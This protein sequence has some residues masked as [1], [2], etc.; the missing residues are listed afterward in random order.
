MRCFIKLLVVVV[1]L[2]ASLVAAEETIVLQP[3]EEGKDAYVSENYSEN[4]FGGSMNL[5]LATASGHLVMA[6]YI[7][8]DLSA[9]PAGAQIS[10]AELEFFCVILDPDDK[11]SGM[12]IILDLVTEGWDEM[13]ITWDNQP[14]S[15]DA[16]R[17]VY[18]AWPLDDDWWP[19]VEVTEFV[20]AWCGGS[21]PNHGFYIYL[22]PPSTD[23]VRIGSYSSDWAGGL[24]LEPKLTI[25][26]SGS[27]IEPASWGAIK[28]AD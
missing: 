9:V 25:T 14:A 22:D 15:S 13:T 6:T 16:V 27:K 3:G 5:E 26:Y 12:N 21:H 17:V 2:S 4:N 10:S 18:P 24:E 8:F 28:A 19:P 1:L 23:T 7:E 11:P 20:E